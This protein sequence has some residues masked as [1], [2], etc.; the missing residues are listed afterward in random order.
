MSVMADKGV[1]IG[2][3][4][5]L[6]TLWSAAACTKTVTV[7]VPASTPPT[8]GSN[9]PGIPPCAGGPTS[10]V[11]RPTAVFLTCAD[12][13]VSVTNITWSSWGTAAA[14]GTGTLNI[15][16]CQ[17]NCATGGTNSYPAS[18][19]VSNPNASSGVPVF[20]DVT[21]I[22]KTGGGQIETSTVPGAWGVP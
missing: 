14:V 4:L 1:R 6:V 18:I 10:S 19:D 11:I 9:L 8:T 2:A 21:A 20:Q 16:T 17:P 7:V 3:L 22:P 12:G 13:G 15:K 5:L